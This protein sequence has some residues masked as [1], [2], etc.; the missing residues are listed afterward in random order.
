MAISRRDFARL[1]AASA[2]A[3][4]AVWTAA[5]AQGQPV[6]IGCSLSLTG[7]LSGGVKAGLIGY[8]LW[9]DDVNA[10]GG[11]LGRPVELVVYDDQSTS[12][13]IPGIYSKLVDVDRVDLLFSPY[14]AN[15]TAVIMPFVK[16]RDRFVVGMY[17]IS[18]NDEVKHD[19]FFQIAPWGPKASTDFCRGFFDLAKANGLKR[20]AILAADAEF[21]KSAAAGGLKIMQEYGMELAVNQ[22]YPP[23]TTDFSAILRNLKGVAPDAVFVCSYP[24]DSTAFVRGVSE[25]GLPASVKLVGG[26]MV[27]PQYAP[28]LENLGPALN[29]FVNFHLYVPEPTLKFAGIQEFLARYEPIARQR[30]VDLL[31]HYIPPFFYAAGQLV[32]AAAKGA[33]SLDQAR[34]AQWLHANPVETIVGTIRF[35]PA[36]DWVERRVLIVQYRGL[37]ARNVEQFRAPGK[38][39]VVDPPALK[40]GDFVPFAAARS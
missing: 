13:P 40:S 7:T 2:V 30:G 14:G 36:G 37:S 20:I 4:P 3:A 25:I 26:A 12:A 5:R 8:E 29:G 39:V 34:M 18:N 35:D 23:N 9:R 27:G 17:G 21:S 19:K 10:A 15:L 6:R 33:G 31:G 38:Q 22:G 16:Q 1:A 24:P 28:V 32:A 11:I